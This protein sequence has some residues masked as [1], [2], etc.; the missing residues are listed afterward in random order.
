VQSLQTRKEKLATHSDWSIGIIETPQLLHSRLDCSARIWSTSPSNRSLESDISTL[1]GDQNLKS[2]TKLHAQRKFLATTS[3]WR[4]DLGQGKP[5]GSEALAC[6]GE[7]TEDL[8]KPSISCPR[9]RRPRL[10]PPRT[11]RT[12]TPCSWTPWPIWNPERRR[13]SS[14]RARIVRLDR[15]IAAL[16]PICSRNPSNQIFF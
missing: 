3:D 1:A 7:V 5:Q 4:F 11:R 16:A 12:P 14:I 10:W 9:R 8:L 6:R 15:G 2:P 13:S